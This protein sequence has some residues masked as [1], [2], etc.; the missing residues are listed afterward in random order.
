[1]SRQQRDSSSSSSSPHDRDWRFRSRSGERNKRRSRHSR[2]SPPPRKRERSRTPFSR[3]RSPNETKPSNKVILTSLPNYADKDALNILLAK[4]GFHP[5]DIRVVRRNTD[6]GS[7]RIFGFVEF[8]DVETAEDWIR[9]N[10]GF[11]KMDDGFQVRLEYSRE[12]LNRERPIYNPLT[13]DW[14]CSKCTINNF[15]RRTNCFKCGTSRKDSEALDARGYG[16]VGVSP[17]DTLL[18]RELPSSVTEES[19]RTS[20]S[21]FLGLTI[22]RIQLASSRLYAFVQMKSTEEASYLLQT[23]NKVVPYVDNCAVIITYSRQ[24]LNQILIMEN[25][26]LLKTQSGISSANIQEDPTNSAAQLAQNAIRLA[27]MGKAVPGAVPPIAHMEGPARQSISTPFGY[28]PTY[29]TPDTNLFQYEP[30]SGYLWDVNTGFYYDQKTGYY[31]SSNTSNWM[32]WSSKFSTYIT[33]EG[34][35]LELKRKLQEE[36]RQSQQISQSAVISAPPSSVD[37]FDKEQQLKLDA[38]ALSNTEEAIELQKQAERTE[39]EK[40]KRKKRPLEEEKPKTPQEIQ[41]EMMKWARRQEKIKMSFKLNSNEV[42][43][44]SC[45]SQDSLSTIARRNLCGNSADERNVNEKSLEAAKRLWDDE[46]EVE[47]APPP[48]AVLPGRMRGLTNRQ[49]RVRMARAELSG[50]LAAVDDQQQQPT[51]IGDGAGGQ[52]QKQHTD[53]DLTSFDQ[54]KFVD[55]N[56]FSCL[57]CRRQFANSETLDKHIQLSNLHKSKVVEKIRE[58]RNTGSAKAAQS[59]TSTMHYRDRAKERR[60]Q[61]GYDPGI[62]S[63]TTNESDASSSIELTALVKASVPLDATN[64]GNKMLKSMGW[65]EGQGLGRNAQGIRDP[66]K[67]EQHVQGAGLG[68]SGSKMDTNLPWKVRNRQAAI[69]RFR[70]LE[71]TTRQD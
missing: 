36:E 69:Q 64:I 60:E 43:A 16:M 65:T 45:E 66:I 1:M 46:D 24:S 7:V 57:L 37:D 21:Q 52:Q 29:T 12:E 62:S 13:S 53:T 28:L 68:A 41:K 30:S 42:A 2:Q 44:A 27:Q 67:A 20:L 70:D 56:K 9:H 4:Q 23:F 51:P 18:I 39:T 34:G 31:Y 35:D 61:H 15:N 25:V 58:L 3:R 26:N 50:G 40:K 6:S 59:D 17:C 63:G 47:A 14:T 8:S 55:R 10:Q 33:C 54:E 5:I 22:Q 71:E 48:D 38:K 32:F 11:L 49:A 19:I